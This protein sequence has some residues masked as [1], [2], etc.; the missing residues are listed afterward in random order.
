LTSQRS[1]SAKPRRKYL[2]VQASVADEVAE[3]AK[4][5]GMT[6]FSY[7]SEILKQAVEGEKSG[8]S[9]KEAVE[10]YRTV[11]M[12]KELNFTPA[13][14]HILALALSSM[15]EDNVESEFKSLGMLCGKYLSIKH[16]GKT[17]EELL[18]NAIQSI[19]WNITD[20]SITT[21]SE[22]LSITLVTSIRDEKN[23]KAIS[24]FIEGLSKSLGLS[25]TSKELVAG[26]ATINLKK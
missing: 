20:L 26:L 1:N 11:K 2:A 15:G 21:H 4:N 9:L 24:S 6:L 23:I 22:N 8:F 19:L 3:I 7:V 14:S 13:P 5:K 16:P 25:I 17:P 10:A 12:L 18:K